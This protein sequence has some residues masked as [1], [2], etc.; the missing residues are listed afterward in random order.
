MNI[1]TWF[2]KQWQQ[3]GIA[4]IVLLPLS[5][6][7][8]GLSMLRRL[9]YRQGWLKSHA[10][11]VPVVIVG[12]ITVGG[13]GKTPLVIY[14][15]EQLKQAGYTPGIISRGYGGTQSGEV[16]LTSLPTEKGD[17]PV[18]MAKRTACPV[19]VNADRVQAG[20]DLLAAHPN[21]NIL[22]SDDG[23]Q[24]YRLQ[25][26]VEIVVLNSQHSFGNGQLLPAGP[27]REKRIRLSQVNA[28]VDTARKSDLKAKEGLTLSQTYNMSLKMTGIQRLDDSQKTSIAQL[29]TKQVLA[30]AGIGHP[31]RFFNLLKGLGLDCETRA[32]NDH[33]A[34]TAQDFADVTDKTLLMTEKDA[35]KCKH[36]DLNDAWYLPVSAQLESTQNNSLLQVIQSALAQTK[37]NLP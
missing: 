13:T 4:Q 34:Y 25:R 12:N 9:A 35:V 2:E 33:H 11:A 18:L 30:I 28:I 20:R 3:H 22:I 15:V 32:F 7:F 36:L 5:F 19:W 1:Q 31:S 10:L 29:Q 37:G 21:C 8:L 14:L 24:H 27:L 23:L 6:L 26:D 16:L 17:E